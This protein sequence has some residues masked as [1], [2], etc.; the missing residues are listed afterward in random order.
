MPRVGPW[1]W[2]WGSPGSWYSEVERMLLLR[3]C[4][5][6]A[7]LLG[8]GAIEPMETPPLPAARHLQNNV[9][10]MSITC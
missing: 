1:H 6:S 5:G 2:A 3:E 7:V 9:A 4:P 10:A 8:A